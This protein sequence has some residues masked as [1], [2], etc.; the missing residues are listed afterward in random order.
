MN[1]LASN[2]ASSFSEALLAEQKNRDS[3]IYD[4]NFAETSL[5]ELVYRY[6]LE[7]V[8]AK[9]G[10]TNLHREV[11]YP[12]NSQLMGKKKSCDLWG[13]LEGKE[14][15]LEMKVAY[16]NTG[17]TKAELLS[18]IE[19]LSV[20]SGDHLKRIYIAV[21]VAST[22]NLPVKLDAIHKSANNINA[23]VINLVSEIPKPASW[24]GWG[25]C[26]LHVSCLVW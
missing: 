13:S 2:L 8:L 18:D 16:E 5:I 17:Y 10:F 20:L 15:W 19:K 26:Y 3:S 6:W 23:D 1:N 21:F 4:G 25:G 22:E 11:L 7:T 12:E 14:Y 9:M 24:T